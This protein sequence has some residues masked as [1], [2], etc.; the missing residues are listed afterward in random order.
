MNKKI[1]IICLILILLIIPCFFIFYKYF[2][3]KSDISL[4]TQKSSN[5]Q[6]AD[7]ISTYDNPI[8]P[9]GFKKV[10]TDSA[11][12][13]LDDN[14]KP[15]G[16]ND[17]LVIEDE[18]GNQFVWIP[19]N[20]NNNEN[21]SFNSDYEYFHQIMEHQGFYISRY[22]AGLPLELSNLR[23][24][25]SEETNNI[26]AKPVSKKNSIAWNYIDVKNAKYNA[27]NMYED[28]ALFLTTLPNQKIYQY[29]LSFI[30]PLNK[31]VNTTDFGNNLNTSFT[32]TGYY[33]ND[34]GKNY[35]Y[36][37]NMK[38]EEGDKLLLSTGAYEKNKIKNIYDYF[39]NLSEGYIT[40][41]SEYNYIYAE[42]VENDYTKFVESS[43]DLPKSYFY[44]PDSKIGFRIVLFLN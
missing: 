10:E 42:K 14:G 37:E 21:I 27:E 1:I 17:G 22:E 5:N 16:W 13:V 8:I 2:Y 34:D 18:N 43:I 19:Y 15:K 36:A 25:I 30:L 23:N 29:V 6:I 4:D 38:K 9:E 28:N 33:S 12:W 35:K 20:T 31:R 44:H 24:N 39:G 41:I 3:K 7:I 40:E 26:K 32:F 11:S